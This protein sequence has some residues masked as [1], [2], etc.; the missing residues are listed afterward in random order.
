LGYC[1]ITHVERILAQ[2]LTS[3]SPSSLT[4]PAQLI[5]IGN[6]L[7]SNNVTDDIV[8]QYIAWA[9]DNIDSVLSELYVTPLKEIIDFETTLFSNIDEYNRYLITAEAAPFEEG[10]TITL[11]DGT[12]NERVVIES[13]VDTP[14]RNIFATR[15]PIG[16]N[17]QA[18]NTR[19]LRVRYSAPITLSSARIAAANI[20]DKYFASQSSPN[21]SD[22]GKFLRKQAQQLL[23]NILNGRTILHGQQ[24]IGYRFVNS[25]LKD[26]YH[27]PGQPGEAKQDDV[28]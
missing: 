28:G 4:T 8:N 23:D 7:A 19:V 13:I 2:A 3:A 6:T 15:E 17:F 11:F 18:D 9:D 25:N 10:D 24:R 26:R 20:Y 16:Y 1:N 22:Y 27:L 14:D 21:E 5:R 12:H